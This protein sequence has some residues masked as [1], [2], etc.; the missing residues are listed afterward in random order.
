MKSFTLLAALLGAASCV[1]LP[2]ETTMTEYGQP[3]GANKWGDRALLGLDPSIYPRA[4]VR[5]A[6]VLIDTPEFDE[7]Q[8]F[9]VRLRFLGASLP[10]GVPGPIDDSQWASVPVGAAYEIIVRAGNAAAGN[11]QVVYPMTGLGPAFPSLGKW[12]PVVLAHKLQVEAR[13]VAPTGASTVTYVEAVAVIPSAVDPLALAGSRWGALGGYG[14]VVTRRVA[15][16]LV[17]QTFLSPD[18]TR[19]QF[20]IHNYSS[21]N[22][23]VLFGQSP[24]SVPAASFAPGDEA[25]T[26]VLPPGGAYESP[27]GGFV[28]YVYGI[29]DAAD[30]TGEAL[31]TYGLPTGPLDN[32]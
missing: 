9:N 25:F 7:P 8:V 27:I 4:S 3:A 15:A 16:S 19:R 12:A 6:A 23:G 21:A 2:E 17:S 11:S 14:Q 1:Y 24:G 20:F 32:I 18:W 22:L 30:A 13:V 10:G 5:S 31:V 29:W 28:G 26:F